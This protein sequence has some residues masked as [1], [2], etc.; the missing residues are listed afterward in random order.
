MIGS[1][2]RVER[3]KKHRLCLRI[4]RLSVTEII[5]G[6][7]KFDVSN[8]LG[9]MLKGSQGGFVPANEQLAAP[10]VAWFKPQEVIPLERLL[11]GIPSSQSNSI[12][13]LLSSTQQQ[14]LLDRFN[15]SV[16][17]LCPVAS[18]DDISVT[19]PED[20]PSHALKL[21]MLYSAVFS[22]QMLE[23]QRLLGRSKE[24][25][26]R[27]LKTAYEDAFC[28]LDIFDTPGIKAFQSIVIYLV[29]QMAA[30]MSRQHC[31]FL[32]AVIRQFQIA[33]FHRDQ[34]SDGEGLRRVKRHLWQQLLFLSLRATEAVG[35]ETALID[36]PG[37]SMPLVDME[38]HSVYAAGRWADS[39]IAIVRYECNK[40]HRMI[41]VEGE[42]LQGAGA[43]FDDLTRAVEDRISFV[44][45]TYLQKL[46]TS[47]TSHKYASTV[48]NA[49]LHRARLM[50]NSRR[51]RECKTDL[52]K[53]ENDQ[54][55]VHSPT[56]SPDTQRCKYTC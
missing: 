24:S 42:A 23:A 44:Y 4:G 9:A 48:A 1:P 2:P 29:P 53:Q 3:Q 28:R 8:Q 55:Y 7:W 34:P 45:Q 6:V 17:P 30:E 51:R 41:F 35:P 33:G 32:A 21:S 50:I 52:A 11:C 22:M 14:A 43:T 38:Q 40:I 54:R 26:A 36:D 16:Y 49:L 31:V 18:L 46:D 47:V 13:A 15:I 19:V 56:R 12:D 25:I 20:P 39:I 27:R 37:A 10:V 5:G